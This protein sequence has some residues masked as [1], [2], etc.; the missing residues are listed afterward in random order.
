MTAGVRTLHGSHET[1]NGT[2]DKP[3]IMVLKGART[4]RAQKPTRAKNNKPPMASTSKM[5]KA[6]PE[7]ALTLFT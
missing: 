5:T 1:T 4:Y 7:M 3:S 6:A 2:S